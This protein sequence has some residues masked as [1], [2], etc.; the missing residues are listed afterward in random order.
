L[1]IR[2]TTPIPVSKVFSDT[3]SDFETFKSLLTK[4]SLT[5]T[6]IWCA[7]LN[8][9][10]SNPLTEYKAK[11]QYGLDIFFNAEEIQRINLF[12]REYGGIDRVA[13]FFRG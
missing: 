5:D 9:I 2:A 7:R 12:V 13:V 4:L 6:L 10:V 1:P 8:L 11:Q 3:S